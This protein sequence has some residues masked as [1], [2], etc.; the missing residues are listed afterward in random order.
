MVEDNMEP[1]LSGT[2]FIISYI[3]WHKV[4]NEMKIILYNILQERTRTGVLMYWYFFPFF[5]IPI[6]YWMVTQSNLLR[7]IKRSKSDRGW[8][9]GQTSRCRYLCTS[10]KTDIT[11]SICLLMWLPIIINLV[12]YFFNSLV[13]RVQCLGCVEGRPSEGEMQFFVTGRVLFRR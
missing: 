7:A 9:A 1:R 2:A 4:V 3:R 13:Q 5:W 6:E 12:Q 8:T 11:E 10:N